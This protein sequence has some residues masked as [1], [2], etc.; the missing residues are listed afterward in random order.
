MATGILALAVVAGCESIPVWVCGII[1]FM[2]KIILAMSFVAVVGAGAASP[3][4]V[5]APR[6]M[7]EKE[8]SYSVTA[9]KVEASLATFMTDAALPPE[10]YALSVTEKGISVRSADKAGAFYAVQTLKQLAAQEN[11]KLVFPCVEIEDFPAYP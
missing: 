8:G 10:G 7:I 3:V 4:L 2:K 9:E 11:G 5:P 6:K 1:W